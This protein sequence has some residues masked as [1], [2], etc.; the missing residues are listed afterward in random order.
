LVTVNRQILFG[1]WVVEGD[2]DRHGSP[3][4]G[5]GEAIRVANL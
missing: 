5:S 1:I 4:T 2:D 3:E